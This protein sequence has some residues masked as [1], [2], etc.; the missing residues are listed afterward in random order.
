MIAGGLPVWVVLAAILLD[1][2]LGDPDSIWRRLPHPVVLIG[3]AIRELDKRFNRKQWSF[4]RR[5]AFGIA[6]IGLLTSM[7]GAAGCAIQTAAGRSIAGDVVVAVAASIFLAQRS[8][9]DH[10]WNVQ[11]ALEGDGVEAGRHAVA[12]IVG[13]DTA[14][15]DVSAVSRAAIESC[16]ES[17]CDGVIA[18]VFWLSLFGLPGLLVYKTVNTADSMIGHLTTRHA[19]FGWAAAKADDVL[20]FVPARLT[21]LLIAAAAPTV[22]G[23]FVATLITAWRDASISSSP[24]AGWSE[25]AMA[26]ALGLALGGPRSYSGSSLDEPFF[27]PGGCTNAGAADVGRSLT[28]LLVACVLNAAVYLPVALAL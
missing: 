18:P 20:N 2:V 12:K 24:N 3:W 22:G 23:S 17:L 4:V 5:R 7:A 15:L 21:A 10:V 28:I 8:L 1:A 16:A 9:H 25:S 19:A 27:N 6:A 26:G 11:T 13:R 14:S